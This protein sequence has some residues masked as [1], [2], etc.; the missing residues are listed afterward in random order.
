[1]TN[2]AT[3]SDK[4]TKSS[5]RCSAQWQGQKPKSSCL[6]IDTPIE[7][8]DLAIYS[9]LEEFAKGNVPSWNSPDITTNFTGTP[10]RL[11]PEAIIRVRNLSA[12]PASNALVH[13]FTAP[14]GIG[15]IQQL[16]ISKQVHFGA[17]Q[18]NELLFPFSQEVL[19]GDQRIGV[20]IKIEHPFDTQ[21]INNQ[22]SQ[23]IDVVHT[24][25]S[26]RSQTRDISV[27]NNSAI[28]QEI[29]L[30]VLA[31]DV[32]ASITPSTS[33]FAPFEQI[34]AKLS[35]NVPASI[36]NGEREITVVGR[37]SDGTVIGGITLILFID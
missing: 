12:I 5:C 31:N 22:G 18:E 29:S 33:N 14:F 27:F 6:Q 23:F 11:M 8:P 20:N 10:T 30:Q 4:S 17:N 21:A 1:M 2:Y 26:G 32:N 16:Q 3:I 13:I 28:A 24:S 35:F 15:T 25:E 37:L 7:R 9:Q 34:V 36:T 19:K